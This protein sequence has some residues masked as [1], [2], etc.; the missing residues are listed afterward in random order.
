MNADNAPALAVASAASDAPAARSAP[1]YPAPI[2][3][4]GNGAGERT[5]FFVRG[6]AASPTSLTT[7][8]RLRDA[9]ELVV[10]E[11]ERLSSWV[12]V[13]VRARVC[14][15]TPPR[16]RARYSCAFVAAQG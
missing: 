8:K 13:C 12:R 1:S 6:Y 2:V 10:L 3:V 5:P 9:G 4:L 16:A 15:S 7:G 14:V 11:D